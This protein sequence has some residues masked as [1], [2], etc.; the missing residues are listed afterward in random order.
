MIS[1]EMQ[2]AM[3]KQINAELFSAYLYMSMA[4]YF[5]ASNLPGCAHWMR[6]QGQEEQT[7]AEKFSRHILERGGKV[8][9]TAIEGPET[10]W[11]SPLAVFQAAYAHEQEVTGMIDK[12]VALAQKGSDNAAG[13]LLQWFV[14][15]QVEEEANAN[16]IVQ[17]LKR[18]AGS[19][20]QILM[21]D[22][23]LAQR[24]D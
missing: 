16:A 23:Q 11:A 18:I 13:V 12:L 2:K 3:N 20:G 4:A 9:L 7:H 21:I 15:E 6:I 19:P 14:T 1:K 17:M 5:E 10:D 22:Q 8:A 24:K